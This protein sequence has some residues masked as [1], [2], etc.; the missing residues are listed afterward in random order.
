MDTLLQGMQEVSTYL[1][2]I[3]IARA[4]IDENE[5]GGCPQETQGCWFMFEPQQVFIR[6]S[7]I[8]VTLFPNKEFSRQPTRLRRLKMDRPT[9]F[10]L[11][12]TLLYRE[13]LLSVGEG[14][15]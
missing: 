12:N 1:D 7:N 9:T 15:P 5:S 10:D 14:S 2:D 6:V 3:L 13:V 4:T 11:M 8:W